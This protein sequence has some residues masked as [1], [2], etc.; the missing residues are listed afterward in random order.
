MR[1][2]NSL[3]HFSLFQSFPTNYFDSKVV[4]K[5]RHRQPIAYSN[6][7][8]SQRP[9]RCHSSVWRTIQ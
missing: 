8:M 6:F 2:V 7:K 3:D 9:G 1:C 4:L 5:N